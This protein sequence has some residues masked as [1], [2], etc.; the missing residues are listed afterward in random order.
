MLDNFKLLK[1]MQANGFIERLPV[2]S[3][4]FRGKLFFLNVMKAELSKHFEYQ[5]ACV[6]GVRKGKGKGIRARD[7][8]RGR[9]EEGKA[10]KE[11]IVFAIRPIN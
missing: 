7:H 2:T 10:C 9:R 5:L 3:C 1:T 11:T 4:P 6:A 8:A